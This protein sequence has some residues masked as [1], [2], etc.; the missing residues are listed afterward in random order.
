M[1]SKPVGGFHS[2]PTTGIGKK[3]E[4][5][6]DDE[7]WRKIFKETYL[8]TDADIIFNE[9]VTRMEVDL[10][11]KLLDLERDD[12][13]LDL[14]CGVGRHSIELAKRS[15]KNVHGLDLSPYLIGIARNNASRLGLPVTFKIGDCRSIP[16]PDSTFD[17]ALV[18]GNSFGYF[19]DMS[20]DMRVLHQIHRVLRPYGKLL[21]DIMDGKFMAMNFEK[22][23]SELLAD[24]SMVVRER[25]L[26]RD[27]KRL[28]TRELLLHPQN[29]ILADNVY[30]VRLYSFS[31]ISDLLKRAG[32]GNITLATRLS[33]NG[34]MHDPGMMRHRMLITAVAIKDLR[35]HPVP[36]ARKTIAVL[37]GD[38]KLPNKAF[39]TE[40][41]S[42][43]FVYAINELKSALY[44]MREYRFIFL[45]DHSTIISELSKL[46][47][48]IHLVLNL[49]DDGFLNDPLNEPHITALLEMLG[50]P[51]TGASFRCLTLAYD[52][53]AVKA[54][55]SSMRIPTPNFVLVHDDHVSG[56][57]NLHF[58]VI[59][60]PNYGDN[61]FGI[62]ASSVAYS[63]SQVESI[64]EDLRSR[65]GYLGPVLIEEL[66]DG[67]DLT[68][69]II[70]NPPSD[71]K[72]LPILTED[73]S[74]LPAG[75]PKI[76]SYEA[77]WLPESDYGAVKSVP[78]ELPR[79]VRH[80]VI[81]WSLW[82]FE[83][84]FCRDYARFDWRLSEEGTPYLL[85]VNPNP[86]WVWDG[87]LRKACSYIG[88]TYRRMLREIIGA[89]ERRIRRENSLNTVRLNSL[90]PAPHAS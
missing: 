16:Y 46:A 74:Q 72:V 24:G 53:S 40:R 64:I 21:L 69:S 5:F 77:K 89:A 19:R 47:G 8:K 28:I 57:K 38:P 62:T 17:V 37:L 87:H 35:H 48:Q 54:I 59:V 84:L 42:L 9:S 51:Y 36:D 39:P 56:L 15:F 2:G 31:E 14:C 81:V 66:I 70:G 55:A 78:A 52:K 3:L 34:G 27:G 6:L 23:S 13:I 88:W 22:K 50:I 65:W 61:S 26:S 33:Y 32:F 85:E 71:Y 10:I 4:D 45:D 73:Y 11:I 86:G 80:K 75:L 76:C 7:W 43:D 68:V 58:P 63:A 30:A 82:M 44:G 90:N 49:C 41:H 20:D 83:R 60:K 29:G 12:K 1:V 79:E 18:M 67:P 25:E